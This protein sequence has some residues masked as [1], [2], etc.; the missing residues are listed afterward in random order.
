VSLIGAHA[1][2]VDRPEVSVPAEELTFR[3]TPNAWPKPSDAQFGWVEA[4]AQR[5]QGLTPQTQKQ[6]A[7]AAIF[8]ALLDPSGDSSTGR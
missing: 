8:N 3:H 1:F 4:V 2:K 7:F 5:V 6:P